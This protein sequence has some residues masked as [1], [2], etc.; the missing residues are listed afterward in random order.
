MYSGIIS[1]K[2][3]QEITNEDIVIWKKIE[4]FHKKYNK[5]ILE[6]FLKMLQG[7]KYK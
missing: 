4:A 1:D 6:F 7:G 3:V 2:A 5:I